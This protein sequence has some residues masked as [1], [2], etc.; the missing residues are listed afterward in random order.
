MKERGGVDVS[1]NV[2]LLK[3]VDDLMNMET[4]GIEDADQSNSILALSRW[5]DTESSGKGNT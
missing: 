2:I 1:C 4:S 5:K 3:L